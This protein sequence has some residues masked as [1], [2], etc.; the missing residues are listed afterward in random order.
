MQK[1]MRL[2]AIGLCKALSTLLAFKWPILSMNI[3]VCFKVT[4]NFFAKLIQ[5]KNTVRIKI[6][7][8]KIQ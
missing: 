8:E 5:K 1:D 4:F 2:K 6:K 3:V 7:K